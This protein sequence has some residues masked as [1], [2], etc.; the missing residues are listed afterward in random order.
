MYSASPIHIRLQPI[1]FFLFII[2]APTVT[3]YPFGRE[4]VKN[5]S[6]NEKCVGIP[7]RFAYCAQFR[8]KLGY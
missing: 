2:I 8:I 1:I 7:L 3:T 5:K 4:I 6:E